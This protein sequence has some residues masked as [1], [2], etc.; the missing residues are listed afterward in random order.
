MH[1]LQKLQPKS[2]ISHFSQFIGQMKL[3]RHMYVYVKEKCNS[4]MCLRGELKYL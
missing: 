2:N 4:T 3:H 1:C